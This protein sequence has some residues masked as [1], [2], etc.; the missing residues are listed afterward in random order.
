MAGWDAVAAGAGA[1]GHGLGS[2][3]LLLVLGAALAIG[4][5]LA[6]LSSRAEDWQPVSLVLALGALM[7]RLTL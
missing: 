7:V 4:L 5:P 6:A 1:P 3:R 2:E